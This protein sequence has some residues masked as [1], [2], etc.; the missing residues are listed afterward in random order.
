MTDGNFFS[1]YFYERS[2][3][4]RVSEIFK[5]FSFYHVTERDGNFSKFCHFSMQQ[6]SGILSTFSIFPILLN[7]RKWKLP[8]LPF[9]SIYEKW[10]ILVGQNVHY[11]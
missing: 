5:L 4:D 7:N 2:E 10:E 8:D 1:V 11:P 6:S 9:L 3:C